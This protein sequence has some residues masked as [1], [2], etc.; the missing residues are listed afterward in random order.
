MS[1]EREPPGAKSDSSRL[2][3]AAQFFGPEVLAELQAL[4]KSERQIESLA[5]ELQ[6]RGEREATLG[7][8]ENSFFVM[9]SQSCSPPASRLR[10]V[11]VAD[12]EPSPQSI[13]TRRTA[14][15]EH[16]FLGGYLLE[17]GNLIDMFYDGEWHSGEYVRGACLPET[18]AWF[19]ASGGIM[20]RILRGE[21]Q[22]RLTPKKRQ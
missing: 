17:H 6:F 1:E 9:K 20:R 13:E 18:G 16:H 11:D 22:V 21:T 3:I 8:S 4:G 15:G 2:R 14:T 12:N 7:E 10:A 19:H 5:R